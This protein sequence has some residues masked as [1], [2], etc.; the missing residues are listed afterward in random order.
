MSEKYKEIL[1]HS[2]QLFAENGFD[3]TSMSLIAKQTGITK[4]AIYYYFN[5][6]EKLIQTL[7]GHIIDEIKFNNFFNPL[8]YTKD[9]FISKLTEDGIKMMDK[10]LQDPYY[11][12]IMNEYYV[13]SSRDAHYAKALNTVLH[14]FLEGFLNLLK[15]AQKYGLLSEKDIQTKAEFLTI[16]VDGLD[17]YSNEEYDLDPVAI[18]AFSVKSIFY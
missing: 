17:K 7:F 16:I 5:S 3:Q 2:Y 12:K 11:N 13:L 9:N 4:P 18:W 15:L 6:K 14:E 1:E 8:E 10:Q